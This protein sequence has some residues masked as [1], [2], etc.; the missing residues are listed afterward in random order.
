MPDDLDN[1]PPSFSA[2]RKFGAGFGV[3]VGVAAFL[4]IVLMANFLSAL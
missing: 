1:P 2:A 3:L 4:A